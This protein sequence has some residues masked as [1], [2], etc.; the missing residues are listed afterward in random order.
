MLENYAT[1][2]DDGDDSDD[3]GNGD[4][5]DTDSDNNDH[6]YAFNEERRHMKYDC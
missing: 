1:D 2:D 6:L 5:N 3:G 4:D